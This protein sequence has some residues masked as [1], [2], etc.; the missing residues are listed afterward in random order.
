M[1]PY[2]PDS[3]WRFAPGLV[4]LTHGTFGATPVPVLEHQRALIDE[5]E[6]DPIQILYREFEDRRD[7]ARIEVARFHGADPEGVVLVP[8]ATTG[9]STVLRSLRLRPGDELLTD[10]HEY[11]AVLNAMRLAADDA[12]A[13]VVVAPIPLPIRHPE[14]VVEALISKVTPRTRL[15]VVSHV[16]SPTGLVFPIEAIVRELDRLGIDTLVDAAHAPGQV[17]VDVDALG[18]A[19]WTGNGHKWLCGPKTSGVLAIRADRRAGI[20]PLVTSHGRNDPREDRHRLWREFD[21]QG[22]LDPTAFLALPEAIRVVGGLHPDGWPGV[23]AANRALALQSRR[24]LEAA[25]EVEPIAPESMVASFATVLVPG[26]STEA[27]AQDMMRAFHHEARIEI[28]FPEWPVRGARDRAT[29]P[30]RRI[31]VRVSAQ[32]Y[33][34]P[35]DVDALIDEMTA[36]GLA[37]GSRA[38]GIVSG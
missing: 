7:A 11:N 8:N 33:N 9:V 22:T 29:D 25:I 2:G 23:M 17:P 38:S 16:T 13:Q 32:L 24:R 31:L 3:P 37:A 10:D 19:Y 28:P 4:Y 12:R 34:E 15:A 1:R 5:L 18:A 20:R 35:A 21:W 26:L 27:E 30:P 6:A 14:E 36:R